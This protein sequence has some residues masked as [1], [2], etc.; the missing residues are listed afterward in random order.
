MKRTALAIAAGNELGV[1]QKGQVLEKIDAIVG[2]LAKDCS[3]AV[4]DG[5]AADA[6]AE[7]CADLFRGVKDALEALP[8]RGGERLGA[9]AKRAFLTA[10]DTAKRYA[11]AEQD[12]SGNP[13]SGLRKQGRKG[14]LPAIT[15][16]EET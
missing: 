7:V 16:L 9:E 2:N 12:T 10:V 14:V 4:D 6:D 11:A 5:L 13:V 8:D 1:G 3:F 15:A